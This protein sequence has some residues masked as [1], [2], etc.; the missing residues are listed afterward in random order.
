MNLVSYAL[1]SN[2][3][4][5]A[6]KRGVKGEGTETPDNVLATLVNKGMRA[7]LATSLVLPGASGVSPF[8]WR[9]Y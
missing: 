3:K 6:A 2:Y 1:T 9:R 8:A 5:D 4:Q 7:T